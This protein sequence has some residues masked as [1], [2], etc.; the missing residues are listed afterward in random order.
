MHSIARNH[1]LL[2]V[3]LNFRSP[4]MLK[5]LVKTLLTLPSKIGLGAM[6]ESDNIAPA[7]DRPIPGNAINS[8]SLFGIMPLI[9]I[10]YNFCA[11][12]KISSSRIKP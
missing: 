6:L 4:L 1:S 9:L 8:S 7:V 2:L 12:V 11:L 10:K 5:N 3:L